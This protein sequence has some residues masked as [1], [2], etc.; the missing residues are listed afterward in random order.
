MT[1]HADR[2]ASATASLGVLLLEHVNLAFEE[3][4]VDR[5]PTADILARLVA[6]EEGPWGRWWGAEVGRD[7]P[8]RAAATDLAKKLRPFK[9]ADGDPIKPRVMRLPDG[10]TPRGY[11]RDDFTSAFERYLPVPGGDAT[12][13]T[14]ATPLASTVAGV[15]CVA[16]GSD[17]EPAWRGVQRDAGEVPETH[18]A[19]SL[20]RVMDMLGATVTPEAGP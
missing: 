12:H 1:L 4:D 10:T 20:Q 19:A 9:K 16:G 17:E 3:A 7:R 5:L 2:D 6:N 8:P 11:H 15:A 18:E 14:P 13:A